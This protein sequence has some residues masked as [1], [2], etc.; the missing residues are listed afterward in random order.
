MKGKI[1]GLEVSS[2]G[3]G[4]TYTGIGAVDSGIGASGQEQNAQEKC[5]ELHLIEDMT[6]RGV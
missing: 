4:T 6:C 1:G 3:E 5:V 2:G